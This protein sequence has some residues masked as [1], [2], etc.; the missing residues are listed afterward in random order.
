MKSD[1]QWLPLVLAL[2]YMIKASYLHLTFLLGGTL[3]LYL[4]VETENRYLLILTVFL[5]ASFVITLKDSLHKIN[6][7]LTERFQHDQQ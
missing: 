5:L 6:K 1:K 2:S 3:S 7:R 4:L